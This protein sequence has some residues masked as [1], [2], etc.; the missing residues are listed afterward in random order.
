MCVL[1]RATQPLPQ[2]LICKVRTFSPVFMASK[3]RLRVQIR[4]GPQ[5]RSGVSRDGLGRRAE[6]CIML[7]VLTEIEVQCVCVRPSRS[8]ALF[9]SH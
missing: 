1:L 4:I 3:M 5:L 2:Y 6:A 9:D 8:S 7:R